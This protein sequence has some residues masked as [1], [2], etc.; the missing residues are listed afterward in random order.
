VDFER[1]DG[2]L[3]VPPGESQEVLAHELSA[4]QRA[5]LRDIEMV[6]RAPLRGFD[7]GSALRFPGQAQFHPLKYL[8]G[9]GTALEKH[10]S[11]IFV[12]T[13]A[14]SVKGGKPG[15]VDTA[16]VGQITADAI[17]VA[18]NI[19]VNDRVMIHAQQAAYRSYVIGVR[20][21][22]D[23]VTR[24]LYWDTANHITTSAW[25]AIKTATS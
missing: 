1:L 10:G 25:Q 22:S 23:S 13:K 20:I 4:L 14:E 3:F 18:T 24:A 2:F 21:P 15:N 6:P 11:R 19:P 9:L 5:G 8:I 17:V 7:T 16:N 12:R